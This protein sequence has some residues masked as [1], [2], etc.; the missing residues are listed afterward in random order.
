MILVVIGLAATLIL[1]LTADTNRNR[2]PD[3]NT[4][5]RVGADGVPILART[6]ALLV[7]SDY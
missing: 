4:Y 1:I 2:S 6:V 5:S 3:P 7:A